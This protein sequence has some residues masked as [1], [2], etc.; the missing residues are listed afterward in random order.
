MVKCTYRLVLKGRDQL[1]FVKRFCE[2]NKNI[3]KFS[4]KQKMH[5]QKSGNVNFKKTRRFPAR[6]K[7]L[8]KQEYSKLIRS[9]KFLLIDSDMLVVG[10]DSK[11][12]AVTQNSKNNIAELVHDSAEGNHFS[13]GFA[14]EQIVIS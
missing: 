2:K 9:G 8:I 13:F 1:S 3:Y 6:I 10:N 12:L 11:R 14:F 7:W 5:D 4:K